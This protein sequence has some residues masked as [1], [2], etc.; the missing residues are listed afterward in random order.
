MKEKNI[1]VGVG[2][3][4]LKDNKILLGKRNEDYGKSS[5]KLNAACTW[6]LPG[7]RLEYSE[8]FD[9][10]ARREAEE[11]TGIKIKNVKI[12][13]V[14]N[15]KDEQAHFVTIGALAEGFKGEPKVMEPDEITE[16]KWFDIN[17]LPKP[18]FFPSERVIECYKK[19]K[20]CIFS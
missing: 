12:I 1:G 8:K 13:C 2:V 17:N 14:S 18:M 5:F 7:G 15:D 9:E 6:T 3:I 11:E 4:L 10:C 20:F 16:W 19:G